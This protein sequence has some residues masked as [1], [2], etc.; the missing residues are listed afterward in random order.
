VS[1]V[2]SAGAG[3]YPPTPPLSSAPCQSIPDKLSFTPSIGS[4]AGA[5]C[6]Q[7]ATSQSST[8]QL[9]NIPNPNPDFSLNLKQPG[10]T[11]TLT[12]G[13]KLSPPASLIPA[14]LSP[15]TFAGYIDYGAFYVSTS[16]ASPSFTLNIITPQVTYNLIPYVNTLKNNIS[17]NPFRF[18]KFNATTGERSAITASVGGTSGTQLSLSISQ[19][20][21]YMLLYTS[22]SAVYNQS[23]SGNVN[24]DYNQQQIYIGPNVITYLF[25]SSS[26]KTPYGQLSIILAG[27][28][29]NPLT[30]DV[31]SNFNN[32]GINNVPWSPDSMVMLDRFGFVDL[33]S[34]DFSG[35]NMTLV[36]TYQK[37][38]FNGF[39]QPVESTITWG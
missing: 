18:Y 23:Q 11:G 35:F 39:T 17:N 32:T 22:N 15:I 20:G 31:I 3:A 38:K 12:F 10:F 16:P 27:T 13:T 36:Y 14:G 21:T 30:F 33:D 24:I 19:P 7:I 9:T 25:P 5:Y 28:S 29:T 34:T 2:T 37:T 6:V 1:N 8:D 26:F 4:P